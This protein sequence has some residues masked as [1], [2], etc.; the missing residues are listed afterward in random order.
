MTKKKK[1][2]TLFAKKRMKK[3]LSG[4]YTNPGVM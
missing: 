3:N 4:E 1:N 2:H